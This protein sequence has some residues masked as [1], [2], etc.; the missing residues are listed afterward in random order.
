MKMKVFYKSEVIEF[1]ERLDYPN[2]T[3]LERVRKLFE[4]Y[5]FQIGPKYVKKVTS[6]GIWELRAGNVRL[7]ICFKGD[8]GFG[9]HIIFKKTQK[10]PLRDIK[11]A[12]RRAK[13]I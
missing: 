11:L 10:L 3:R 8:R 9:V 12:E 1:I 6:S 2:R 5:G 7:L 4:D 13:E